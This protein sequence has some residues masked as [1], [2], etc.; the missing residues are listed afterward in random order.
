MKY[1]D[2]FGENGYDSAFLTTYAFSAQAFE[3]VPFPRL[4]GAGC[5]NISVLADR[6]MLN[7]SFGEFG[8]PRY[9][10]TLYHVVK[11]AV[12]G[13][14]HPKITLLSGAGEGRLLIGSANLT[15][16]G[17]GGNRE[18]V[19][20][21]PYSS[22]ESESLP[23][24][25]QALRYIAR[26]VPTGDPW[27]PSALERAFRHA[28]WLRRAFAE[29]VDDD[30]DDLKLLIDRPEDTVLGQIA[31]AIDSDRIERLVVL[32]PY[33]DEGLEG[34]RQLR[35]VLGLPATDLLLQPQ[36]GLFPFESL[37]RQEGVRL[38]DATTD[39]SS[40][41][42]HAKL[43]LAQGAEWDHVISGS[44]NCSFPALMGPSTTHGNAEA[45][46]YKRV[47]RDKALVALGLEGYEAHPLEISEFP[48]REARATAAPSQPSAIDAGNFELRNRTLIWM[49]VVHDTFNPTEIRLFDRDGM[50]LSQILRVESNNTQSWG[51]D[52]ELPR[53]KIALVIGSHGARSAPSPIIDLDVL[54]TSTLPV[55]RGRK[56]TITDNLAELE[57]EDLAIL[58]ALNELE[59][60]EVV[61]QRENSPGGKT[62][63]RDPLSGTE[64]KTHDVLPYEAF[65]AARNRA[66]QQGESRPH[67]FGGRGETPAG[68]INACLN[69]LVGLVSEDL[70]EGEELA[71]LRDASTDLRTTEPSDDEEETNSDDGRRKAS[72]IGA[73]Q[74]ARAATT[75]RK[76]LEAVQAFEKRTSSLKGQ[77]I[78]TTE[79]VR[80]RAMLQVVLASA[81]P[82]SG[83][84]RD[85]QVLP[86]NSKESTE[87]PRLIG[88][89]LLQHFGT[90][91]ALQSL[92]VE[93]DESEHTRV[94]DY[95]AAA[96]FAAHAAV[97]GAEASPSLTP[98][99]A[100]LAAIAADLDTLVKAIAER[101]AADQ[102]RLNDLGAKLDARFAPVIGL[103]A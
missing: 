33:W 65:V 98:I 94:L 97:Q 86:L 51:I 17:L 3:D 15:G 69:R 68:L 75:A 50:E 31:A 47:P 41:F 8:P 64:Q 2:V 18:L 88:R 55:R 42:V 4:R 48:P 37:A 63:S 62:G 60:L 70:S 80:L 5:R 77:R 53:P 7:S 79:L 58:E 96:R 49:P 61:E 57:H 9:A 36:A 34:L 72:A 83:T 101:D 32:S 13:A 82:I 30:R 44:M 45:G 27:F 91:R 38:F 43:F 40:R 103:D 76:F 71:L 11:I 93:D 35:I 46:I 56:R 99:Q 100:K 92:D 6:N 66:R 87:W 14:F 26:H 59:M 29:E 10:G 102:A 73:A 84:P 90:V 81:M 89:L 16:V 24:F 20:D 54:A 19:A 28:P 21:I 74:R 22:E 39:G 78:T 25:G 12:P 95:L 85:H 1:Y 23:L 67:L 52:P